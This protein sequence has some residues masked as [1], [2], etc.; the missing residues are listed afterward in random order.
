[1]FLGFASS[2]SLICNCNYAT[3]TP[4]SI[5]PSSSRAQGHFP[6]RKDNY[7]CVLLPQT[8]TTEWETPRPEGTRRLSFPHFILNIF[9]KQPARVRLHIHLEKTLPHVQSPR[10]AERGSALP[11]FPLPHKRP[12]H[13]GLA[14]A[15]HRSRPGKGRPGR[16]LT[17][18][19]LPAPCRRRRGPWGPLTEP[20]DPQS[21]RATSAPL[22][23]EPAPS[24][25][26]APA[27]A[28]TATSGRGGRPPT[29]AAH[30]LQRR[31]SWC[32]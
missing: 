22:G 25:G 13:R 24:Y 18:W 21:C 11:L 16:V 30:W 1:M 19:A 9:F 3:P 12:R 15:V 27:A 14:L 17:S 4:T 20:P 29:S 2:H 26:R 7:S 6:T 8:W 5:H 32:W 31:Q 23:S 10:A 28:T